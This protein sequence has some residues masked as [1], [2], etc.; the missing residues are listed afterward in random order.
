MKLRAALVDLDLRGIKEL[1]LLKQIYLKLSCCRRSEFAY[2]Q[3]GFN[4]EY[5]GM[6]RL[7]TKIQN[8]YTLFNPDLDPK[9]FKALLNN[10]YIVG[11]GSQKVA[12]DVISYLRQ[13]NH[14][15]KKLIEISN[16][17]KDV[18]FD[19]SFDEAM[20]DDNLV[21]QAS[22]FFDDSRPDKFFR[23][24]IATLK[25]YLDNNYRYET[26]TTPLQERVIKKFI[27]EEKLK[28]TK[29]ALDKLK[30]ISKEK[31]STAKQEV[32]ESTQS[33]N[34]F[35]LARKHEL[36]QEIGEKVWPFKQKHKV[37]FLR[38]ILYLI[39]I[40]VLVRGALGHDYQLKHIVPIFTFFFLISYHLSQAI[41]ELNVLKNMRI[42]YL[43]RSIVAQTFESFLN[44]NLSNDQA[45]REGIT[46]EAAVTMF[47]KE[48]SGYL[49]KDQMEPPSA[50]V[51]E[52]VKV[53]NKN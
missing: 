8:F 43:H 28:S 46:K 26:I 47:R 38:V 30:K 17:N 35:F 45:V 5:L 44:A 13:E 49:S 27:T 2:S 31:L 40:F 4:Q 33:L 6:S 22:E 41:R 19:A 39:P 25:G 10:S 21:K 20:T 48:S 34:G 12:K 16:A 23:E 9:G 36:E 52:V 15:L 24:F 18:S 37:L 32:R 14:N 42:S 11:D 1:N 51:Q 3:H 53:F 29:E 7:K 50:P